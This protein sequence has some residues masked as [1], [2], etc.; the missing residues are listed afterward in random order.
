MRIIKNANSNVLY[1]TLELLHSTYCAL[2]WFVHADFCEAKS[3]SSCICTLN[4]DVL[5][6]LFRFL[7]FDFDNF[8]DLHWVITF[9]STDRVRVRIDFVTLV[10]QGS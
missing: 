8:A 7:A 3:F 2:T 10:W 6:L 9:L 4:N 1:M 5:I